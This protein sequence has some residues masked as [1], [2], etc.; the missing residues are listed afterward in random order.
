MAP[1]VQDLAD[2][3]ETEEYVAMKC[4]EIRLSSAHQQKSREKVGIKFL[5]K[6]GLSA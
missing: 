6:L 4:A 1:S 2:L 5:K 3:T